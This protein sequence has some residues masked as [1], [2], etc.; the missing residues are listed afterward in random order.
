MQIKKK[1]DI[2]RILDNFSSNAQWDASGEKHY[3]VFADHKRNGQWTL[4]NYPDNRFSVHGL[5][6]DYSDENESFFDERSQI[7][8]FIWGNRSAFNAILKQNL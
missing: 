1:I 6:E 3:I 4:M 2:E 7:V 8:S 5:G